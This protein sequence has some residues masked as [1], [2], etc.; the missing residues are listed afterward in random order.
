MQIES[1]S[2]RRFLQTASLLCM[3]GALPRTAAALVPDGDAPLARILT[4]SDQHSAYERAAQLLSAFRAE[5]ATNPAPH[6]ILINGD[7]FEHGNVVSVRSEG[8]IDWAF[9]AALPSIAP[10]VFNLGNHDNDLML[11]LHEVVAKIRSLGIQ[12]ISNIHDARTG[13]AYAKASVTVPVSDRS[14]RVVGIATDALHTYPKASREWLSI[15]APADWAQTHLA[16]HLEG[17]DLTLVASHAGVVPDR[18][19][20]PLL[21]QGALM[22]GGHN[23]LR[24]EHVDATF[25]YAHTGSWNNFYT[26]AEYHA[27]RLPSVISKPVGL[28]APSDPALAELTA[29]TLAQH[30]TDQDRRILGIA[31]ETLSLA[32]TGRRLAK[33]MAEVAG[34]D[35]GLIGHTTL[36]TGLQAGPVQQFDFDAVVRFDGKLMTAMITHEQLALILKRVNQDRPMSLS[37][38]TGDFAY[39]SEA[40]P[41]GTSVISIATNDWCAMNQHEYFGTTDIVFTEAPSAGIKAISAAVL[42]NG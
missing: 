12:V 35:M 39:A 23:H 40:P 16:Q 18:D 38:R 5:V 34:T 33:G 41:S 20:L 1:A 14:I 2:R 11:D 3:L 30:L 24:F 25:T 26:V 15:P 32:E 21:P 42:L 27:N 10:T 31:P 4:L 36:G 8:A 37:D 19:I 6:V 7:L 13:Q 29:A 9:L 17:A 22:I 28:F